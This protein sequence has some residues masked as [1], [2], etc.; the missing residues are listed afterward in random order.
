M[1]AAPTFSA[2]RCLC[3][4]HGTVFTGALLSDDCRFVQRLAEDKFGSLDLQHSGKVPIVAVR[5][6]V[7]SVTPVEAQVG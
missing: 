3:D 6:F 2:V 4:N 1:S 7:K 5:S